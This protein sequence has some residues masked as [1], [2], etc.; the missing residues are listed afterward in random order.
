MAQSHPSSGEPRAFRD[1][2]ARTFE[3]V[4]TT[5]PLGTAPP[6]RCAPPATRCA[7]CR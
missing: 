7:D 6:H 1:L 4:R 5:T 3:E 2:A